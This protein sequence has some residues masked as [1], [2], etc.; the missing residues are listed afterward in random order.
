MDTYVNEIP[1]RGRKYK[2]KNDYNW[3]NWLMKTIDD[4][5]LQLRITFWKS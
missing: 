2:L 1:H 3:W 5:W 4:K